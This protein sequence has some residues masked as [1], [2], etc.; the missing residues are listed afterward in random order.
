M[1]NRLAAN[2]KTAMIAKAASRHRAVVANRRGAELLVGHSLV[3]L[4]IS[5][6]TTVTE[7]QRQARLISGATIPMDG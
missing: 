7:N 1:P 3:V 6:T 4:T 5:N 2:E